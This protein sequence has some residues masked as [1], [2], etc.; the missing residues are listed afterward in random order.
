MDTVADPAPQAQLRQWQIGRFVFDPAARTLCAEGSSERI[1]GKAA[2][3]LQLL[4]EHAGQVLSRE[5]LI[6]EVWDGNAYTGATALTHTVSQLRR[7]LRATAPDDAPIET[8]SK[9]GYRLLWPAQRRAPVAEATL[10][11]AVPAP[12]EPSHGPPAAA[13]PRRLSLRQRAG[14]VSLLALLA[15]AAALGWTRR[16]ASSASTQ[17]A[18]G[19]RPMTTLEGVEQWPSYSPDGRF[20]AYVWRR[21]G[22]NPRLRVVDLKQPAAPPRE[23]SDPKNLM[24]RPVWLG[25][26]QLAYLQAVHGEHC[27][28][29][30]LALQD[31]SNPRELT[32]CLFLR[33]AAALAASPDGAWLAFTRRSAQTSGGQLL[34]LRRLADGQERTL[35]QEPA[36]L[37]YG[38]MSW[39]HDGR[40][41]AVL[42]L[43]DTV[44]DLLRVDV[45]SGAVLQLTNAD[46]PIWAMAW[47]QD[48]SAVVFSAGM[49]GDFALWQVGTDGGP[50]RRFS[51]VEN[52]TSLVAIPDGSGD[53]AASVR[54]FDDHIERYALGDGSAPP[55]LRETI[56][57]T[58]RDLYGSAC[59]DAE[60]PLFISFRA[61]RIG[62]WYRDG[63]QAEPRELPLPDDGIPE[64]AACSPDGH[65]YATA[66]TP[67][68]GQTGNRL[69]VGRLDGLVDAKPEVIELPAMLS[70]VSWSEDGQSLLLI[71]GDSN[72]SAAL[73]R[74]D[75]GR[76]SLTALADEQ[77]R[78][79]REIRTEGRRWLYFS[80]D[81]HRGIWRRPLS[82]D[83]RTTGPGQLV[84][85][86]LALQDWG[87]WLWRDGQLW[88]ISRSPGADR[89]LRRDASGREQAVLELPA[90]S[91]GP[92]RSLSIDARGQALVSRQGSAQAD[93]MR[94][95]EAP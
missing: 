59:T 73:W 5:Q 30:T 17:A 54:L 74:Y 45:Q 13:A 42:R 38:Q 76:H 67:T 8:I 57:S 46:K 94:V 86:D 47:R 12:A 64:P 49:A 39:S 93:L 32:D 92:F 70:N 41:L 79:G 52:A 3:V 90:G 87:N 44:G 89:L 36:G 82:E 69:V 71:S 20:L 7:S 50:P 37:G 95:P 53:M 9:S 4:A 77:A 75:L 27:R 58:S 29:M 91:V 35:A 80:R 19:P 22:G 78:F 84:V 63:A 23:F 31:G 88:R 85:E 24:E 72:G 81:S 16:P 2:R 28:V 66:L 55:Q 21:T 10:L 14:L 83:G 18:P 25:A 68:P 51:R 48:D 15:L 61:R 56:R 33:G 26:N 6:A 11:A 62:L 65:R 40:H 43:K 60:H 34:Q 1:S